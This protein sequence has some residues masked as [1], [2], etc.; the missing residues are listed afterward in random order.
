VGL[1]PMKLICCIALFASGES[2]FKQR[3]AHYHLG[4]IRSLNYLVTQTSLHESSSPVEGSMSPDI[5]K[6]YQNKV[7]L[8]RESSLTSLNGRQDDE[9]DK[10]K[11]SSI[12]PDD[13]LLELPV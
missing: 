9:D 4:I 10:G 5:I 12:N 3:T 13:L 1:I 6:N 2:Y 8:L 11:T 7:I